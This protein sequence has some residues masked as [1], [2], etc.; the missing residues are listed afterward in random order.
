MGCLYLIPSLRDQRITEKG[1]KSVRAGGGEDRGHQKNGPLMKMIKSSYG[2]KDWGSAYRAYMGSVSIL[3]HIIL[4]LTV[5]VLKGF[6]TVE[7]VGL[8]FLGS[9]LSVCLPNLQCNNFCLI[10]LYFYFATFYYYPLEAYSFSNDGKIGVVPEGYGG[11]LGRVEGGEKRIRI[12]CG[13]R[14]LFSKKMRKISGHKKIPLLVTLVFQK[15]HYLYLFQWNK[16]IIPLRL[17]TSI[18]QILISLFWF[19]VPLKYKE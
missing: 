3:L 14:N 12:S 10:L 6:L 1:K 17:T 2:H 18:F 7:W 13:W 19:Y 5:K 16:I 11:D 8:W 9:F 4:W 15:F